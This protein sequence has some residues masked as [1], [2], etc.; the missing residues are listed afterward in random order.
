M[1]QTK[2]II[3][4]N[5]SY[6]IDVLCER[7]D[8]AVAIENLRRK[9][10]I[11]PIDEIHLSEEVHKES[12]VQK[13][14][15]ENEK[16]LSD[17][18]I[19]LETKKFGLTGTWANF[20]LEYIFIDIFAY[21]ILPSIVIEKRD[22]T[23]AGTVMGEPS[24]FLRIFPETTQQDIV[25]AWDEINYFIHGKKIKDKRKKTSENFARDKKIHKLVR[26]GLSAG[27]ICDF[28][29]DEYGKIDSDTIIKADYRFRKNMGIKDGNSAKYRKNDDEITTEQKLGAFF[30]DD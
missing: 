1:R 10:K 7:P 24:Y 30:P 4:K 29:F 23:D 12:N 15:L 28:L 16:F 2:I 9:W 21:K 19:I 8:F 27:D 22:S 13:K 6:F 25:G 18:K 14:L 26:L 3:N 20:I 5:S 11:N 17:V